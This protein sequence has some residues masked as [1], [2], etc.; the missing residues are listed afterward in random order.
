MSTTRVR[1]VGQLHHPNRV[2]LAET[3]PQGGCGSDQGKPTRVR[4]AMTANNRAA[5]GTGIC[6]KGCGW[7]L[8]PRGASGSAYNSPKG[9]LF[10]RSNKNGA[11]G[12]G[13]S[14]KGSKV[15]DTSF[16]KADLVYRNNV[17]SYA[18]DG[19]KLRPKLEGP[20]KVTEA[21]GKGT[22]KLRNR[23]GNILP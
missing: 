7:L 16:K 5:F 13:Y 3:T 14:S 4:L 21:L 9:C 8:A 23:K 11:F 22:Y 2:R 1:L 18:K 17:A 12:L 6:T 10:L 15:R 20:Y 19:R